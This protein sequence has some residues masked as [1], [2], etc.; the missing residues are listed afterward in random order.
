MS[1]RDCM[2]FMKDN[3]F[4]IPVKS[5]C[6]FSPY[7]SDSFWLGLKK[8]IGTAWETALKVDKIIRSRENTTI[9]DEMYLHPSCKP[10]DQVD[11]KENQ[12]DMF[13]NEC[14]GLKS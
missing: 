10:L 2:K 8:E 9:K 13:G 4:P 5:A 7:H 6:V 11:L 12:I 1:R 3:G 14:E